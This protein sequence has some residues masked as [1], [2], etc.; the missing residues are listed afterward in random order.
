MYRCA[1]RRGARRQD[2]DRAPA[3]TASLLCTVLALGAP[4]PAPAA[5]NDGCRERADVARVVPLGD[6]RTVAITAGAGALEVV[7][8]DELRELRAAG[9]ACAGDRASVEAIR[10]EVTRRGER[11]FVETILPDNGRAALDLQLELP[12]DLDVTVRD[13]SGHVEVGGV[14]SLTIED[15]SG[16][17]NVEN[18][19]EGV[20]VLRDSSGSIDI[21]HVG[22]EVLIDEDSSGS[23]EIADAASV[24][25]VEDS[26]GSIRVRDIAGNVYIGRDS[27]GSISVAD[28]GGDFVVGRDSS[29]GVEHRNVAGVVRI[30]EGLAQDHR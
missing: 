22:G 29:G 13:S 5:W 26:S 8:R 25:I 21:R 23:I 19:A 7:G 20:H 1:H 9:E 15:S 18:V 16:S 4:S 2:R 24:R 17:I 14:R 28:V 11:L 3:A 12:G 27:S 10:L 6:V 30:D